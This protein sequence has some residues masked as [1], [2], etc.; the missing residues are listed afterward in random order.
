MIKINKDWWKDFFNEVYLITD[1]RSVCDAGLTRKE[2]TL[3]ENTLDLQ[4]TDRILDLCG[5]QGRHSIEL[6]K[7]GY[8]DLTVLDY[9][10]Y[11]IK[12]GKNLAKKSNLKIKFL[13]KDA[14]TT[15]L[16]SNDYSA[17]FV[18]ANSF[19]Y[20]IYEKDNLR[21][22]KEIYRL[23]KKDGKL[24]LDLTDPDF[25]KN[26]L[27]PLS[28]HE[29]NQDTI[30]LRERELE[31]DLLKAREIVLSKKNGLIRDGRYSERIYPKGKLLRFLKLA[32]FKNISIRKNLSLHKHIKDYGFLT[33]R[34]LTTATK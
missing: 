21:I 18:M 8:Q 29:P 19:G 22:L 26:N 25:V 3:L 1:A 7:R 23:L 9:S 15:G 12:L 13:K 33:S 16:K 17:I 6:A 30:V 5:G 31:R 28:W 11:L 34:M 27:K 14:R 20:F 2:A 24:L 10:D 4:K 32:G